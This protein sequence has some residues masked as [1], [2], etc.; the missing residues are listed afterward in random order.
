M[1]R[2]VAQK[3][4]AV[5]VVAEHLREPLGRPDAL[6]LPA[7]INWKR[8]APGDAQ[9]AKRQLGLSVD[10][11]YVL[12]PAAPS[13]VEKRYDLA[14]AGFD[15]YRAATPQAVDIELIALDNV[16]HERVPLFMNACEAVLMTSAFEAS[17]VTVR[18]ALACNVPVICTDVGDARVVMQGIAGCHIVAAD[19]GSIASA[20]S[21]TLNGPRRVQSR[22]RMHAY[23][24]ETVA[25]KLV[26]LY[27]QVIQKHRAAGP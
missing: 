12:F 4:D 19:P 3:V 16:P 1:K 10:K 17:P 22:E 21:D 5:V 24:L 13:R 26:A 6:W 20:L 2:Y 25:Q 27:D 18:E 7:G 9:E 11:R 15:R 14:R 23:A 8:F